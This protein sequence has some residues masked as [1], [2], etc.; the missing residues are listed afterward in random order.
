VAQDENAPKKARVA[1]WNPSKGPQFA[2]VTIVE[3]SDFQ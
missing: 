1:A 3:Y 2:K